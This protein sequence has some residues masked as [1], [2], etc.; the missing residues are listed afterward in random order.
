MMTQADI[1]AKNDEDFNGFSYGS[2]IESE[3]SGKRNG[4]GFRELRKPTDFGEAQLDKT[5]HI[6]GLNESSPIRPIKYFATD[7]L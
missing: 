5:V 7:R 6:N 3:Q 4:D 2:G 1:L